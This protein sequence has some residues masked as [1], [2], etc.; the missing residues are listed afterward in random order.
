[1]DRIKKIFFCGELT[2]ICIGPDQTDLLQVENLFI[3]KGIQRRN[4]T[5]ISTAPDK[6]K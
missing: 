1:M 3:E 2:S 4:L 5:R 6:T